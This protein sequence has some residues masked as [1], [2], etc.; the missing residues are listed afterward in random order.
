MRTGMNAVGSHLE[1]P[2][3]PERRTEKETGEETSGL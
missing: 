2:F 1:N 3:S